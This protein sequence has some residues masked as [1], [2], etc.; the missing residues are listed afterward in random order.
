MHSTLPVFDRQINTRTYKITR[1]GFQDAR[2]LLAISERALGSALLEFVVGLPNEGK[3]GSLLDLDLRVVAK[4]LMEVLSGLGSEMWD[5]LFDM[6]GKTTQVYVDK[7]PRYLTLADQDTWWANYPED[8][9]LW[10][11]AVYEVQYLD[12]LS[13][14]ANALGMREKVGRQSRK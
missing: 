3:P 7:L 1:L 14:G 2:K 4:T 12:F 9:V 8:L 11:F 13:G 10:I 5:E 6:L